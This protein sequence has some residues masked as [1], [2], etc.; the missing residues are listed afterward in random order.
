MSES[1]FVDI[2]PGEFNELVKY[3]RAMNRQFAQGFAVQLDF[4]D[5]EPA[6]ELRIANFKCRTSSQGYFQFAIRDSQFY[7]FSRRC[8]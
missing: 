4:S 3:V 7:E 5:G 2:R 6:N 1:R 8:L